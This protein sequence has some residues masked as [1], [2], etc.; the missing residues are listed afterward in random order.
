MKAID[1]YI[2]EALVGRRDRA[3]DPGDT[4]I[5]ASL[6]WFTESCYVFNALSSSTRREALNK[7]TVKALKKCTFLKGQD[8]IIDLDKLPGVL[9]E[10]AGAYPYLMAAMGGKGSLLEWGMEIEKL[11]PFPLKIK[12]TSESKIAQF[13]NL[14]IEFSLDSS[15]CSALSYLLEDCQIS[16]FY[17]DGKANRAGAID[18]LVLRGCSPT[19]QSFAG[20]FVFKGKGLTLNLDK[21]R[22][23][24]KLYQETNPMRLAIYAVGGDDTANFRCPGMDPEYKLD[25][26]INDKKKFDEAWEVLGLEGAPREQRPELSGEAEAYVNSLIPK[27]F[28]GHDVELSIYK[29]PG[30]V[31]APQ[32]YI[33]L[34]KDTQ[35]RWTV[36]RHARGRR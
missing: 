1:Q 25:M 13:L 36:K 6:E 31:I 19:L 35:D 33:T 26:V 3:I 7:E 14:T 34:S 2:S 12:L 18:G 32:G 24:G 27:D 10:D 16:G 4:K 29:T 11:P 9:V 28:M 23:G 15:K 17:I 21:E 20:S 5:E 8:T 22:S 30:R